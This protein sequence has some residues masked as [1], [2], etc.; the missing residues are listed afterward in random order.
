[1]HWVDQIYANNDNTAISGAYTVANFR[2][3]D[4]YEIGNLTFSPYLGVKN[5]TNEKYNGNVRPNSFGA[6][7]YEPAPTRNVYGGL[8]VRYDFN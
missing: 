4:D 7:Y 6:R 8:K 3:G 5:F 1:L 2:V